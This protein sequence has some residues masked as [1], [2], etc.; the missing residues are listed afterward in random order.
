MNKKNIP[1]ASRASLVAV[2]VG[3]YG[4]DGGCRCGRGGCCR[5]FG[6]GHCRCF[7]GHAALAVVL[8]VLVVVVRRHG[9]IVTWQW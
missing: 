6:G 3:C 7:G 9:T 4:G 8:V 2:V 5:H 1:D